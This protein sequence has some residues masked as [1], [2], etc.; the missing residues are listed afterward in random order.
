MASSITM[1]ARCKCGNYEKKTFA[2][3]THRFKM[4]HFRQNKI[5]NYVCLKCSRVFKEGR[6]QYER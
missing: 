5:G 1:E 3:T 4:E 6:F 2:V